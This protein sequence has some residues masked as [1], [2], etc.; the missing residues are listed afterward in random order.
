MQLSTRPPR[1]RHRL[2]TIDYS[3]IFNGQPWRLDQRD[4]QGRSQNR[5]YDL[6]RQAAWRRKLNV[7]IEF[8]G[9]DLIVQATPQPPTE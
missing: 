7:T 4:Y 2:A 1:K 6:V 5:V 3:L 9:D 8:D